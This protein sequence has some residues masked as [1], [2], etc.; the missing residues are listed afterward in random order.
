[1]DDNPSYFHLFCTTNKEN[2]DIPLQFRNQDRFRPDQELV[3]ENCLFT[4]GKKKVEE[5]AFTADFESLTEVLG[6]TAEFKDI[7]IFEDNF[8][9]D[10]YHDL[11]PGLKKARVEGTY[12]ETGEVYDLKRSLET[13]KAI[14]RFFKNTATE[15]YPRLKKLAGVVKYYNYV[16]ERID[17][18][19]SKQG[20]IRDNAS[21]ELRHIRGEIVLK[22][23]SAGKKLQSLL[24]KAIDEG[25][26][27]KDTAVSIRNGRQVIPV[28]ASTKGR[29]V[30]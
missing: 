19:L 14:L 28:P 6:Q 21:P 24:K 27:E 23:S 13:I 11:L 3:K 26:V 16:D 4:P 20:K 12:L 30:A 22:T 5:M 17:A 1:M 7:C 25:I 10:N 9:T 2:L 18:I 15:K 8:P 29:S